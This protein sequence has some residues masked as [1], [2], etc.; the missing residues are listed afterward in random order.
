M[1]IYTPPLFH[2]VNEK[3]LN[4]IFEGKNEQNYE[5]GLVVYR[6]YAKHP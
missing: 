6:H 2:L 1:Q 3:L 4:N 5:H